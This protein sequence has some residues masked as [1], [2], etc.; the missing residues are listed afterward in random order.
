[1]VA[2]SIQP[3]PPWAPPVI[4]AALAIALTTLNLAHHQRL[5][6]PFHANDFGH[7]YLAA[8]AVARGENPYDAATLFRLAAERGV[9]RLNPYVYPPFLALVARPLG[10]LS[11][12]DAFHIWTWLNTA[13]VG[14]AAALLLLAEPRSMSRPLPAAAAALLWTLFFPAYRSFS[15]GQLNVVLLVIILGA[16][17]CLKRGRQHWAGVLLALGAMIKVLPAFLVGYLLLRGAWRGAVAFGIATA[18]LGFIG[19]IGA[20]FDT[21]LAY[22]TVLRQMNYGSSTWTELNQA[23]QVDL[24]NESWPALVYRLFTANPVTTPWLDA[25]RLA[26]AVALLGGLLLTAVAAVRTLDL[27]AWKS[28]KVRVDAQGL[29]LWIL[30]MLLLPSLCW[31]HYFVIAAPWL[32]LALA[33]ALESRRWT[34]AVVATLAGA[35]WATP[36]SY[37]AFDPLILGSCALLGIDPPA[38]LTAGAGILLL[39]PKLYAA[40]ALFVVLALPRSAPVAVDNATSLQ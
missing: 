29:G 26:L 15:A 33:D 19:I 23:F 34:R 17:L 12:Q 30:V 10:W 27:P 13:L 21:T 9:P 38:T 39:S 4:A 22:F 8:V 1:M 5:T 28:G 2:P 24:F 36:Y 7:V 40:L 31:D 32:V 6:G 25:P 37:Q 11:F 20:G 18:I 3:L 14:M 16:Y 35:I